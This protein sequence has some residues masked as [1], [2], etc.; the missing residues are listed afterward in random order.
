MG[1]RAKDGKCSKVQGSKLACSGSS[2]PTYPLNLQRKSMH[3]KTKAP[4]KRMHLVHESFN[5]SCIIMYHHVSS[6]IIMYHHVSSCIIMYHHVS[7]CIIMYHHVS[8]FAI[9]P[10][11]SHFSMG[12]SARSRGNASAS[13]CNRSTWHGDL[14]NLM[15]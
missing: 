11:D 2:Y 8:T 4:N 10:C 9:I 14:L 7:S 3:R 15:P 6:C 5:S 12:H 13:P 1:I